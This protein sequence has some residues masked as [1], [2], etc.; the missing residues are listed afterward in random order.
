MIPAMC[1]LNALRDKAIALTARQAVVAT[2]APVGPEAAIQPRLAV[3]PA[4]RCKLM[5]AMIRTS[6]S[7]RWREPDFR[8]VAMALAMEAAAAVAETAGVGDL[9][10]RRAG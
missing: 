10:V 8:R 9:A 4:L 1:R 7:R 3:R 5:P 6:F 2:I